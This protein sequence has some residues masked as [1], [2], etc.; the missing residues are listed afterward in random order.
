MAKIK[1]DISNNF[2]P[3]SLYLYGNYEEDGVTPHF[4]LF[5]WY[6]WCW[7]GEGQGKLG[8]MVCV[9]GE[10][11]TKDLIRKTGMLS[12]NLVSE[13][14]LPLADYY[15]C[16]SGQDTP[17]KMKRLPTVERGQALKVPTIAESPVS[18]ELRVVKEE[19]L[20][21]DASPDKATTLF[22][23][24]VVNVTLDERLCDSSMPV[25]ERMKLSQSVSTV[26]EETYVSFF[27]Q[28]L[29]KWGEPM[30]SL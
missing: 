14:L 3:Q 30:K 4:G 28:E 24:E 2:C 5:C 20:T 13:P 10:K 19:A 6:G 25:I 29:G 7:L 27:G 11:R 16:V 22:L 12:A 23:C 8:A 26:T 18:F 1:G 21:E 9:G 17:D 15:G